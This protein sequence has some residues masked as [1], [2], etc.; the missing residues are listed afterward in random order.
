METIK[1]TPTWEEIVPTVVEIIRNP[2]TDPEV[3]RHMTE[4]LKR[5]S[6]LADAYAKNADLKVMNP[7]ALTR[8]RNS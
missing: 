4:Y 2:D 3:V 1:M 6:R 8:K 5:M 7:F